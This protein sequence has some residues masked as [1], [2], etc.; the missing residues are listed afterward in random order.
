MAPR[1]DPQPGE[2]AADGL[3][4]T[5]C[6]APSPR[7]VHTAVVQVPAHAHL[8]D[9]LALCMAHPQLASAV[10]AVAAGKLYCSVWGT[11]ATPDQ[12]LQP[13]DRI[14]LCRPL[15]VDPKVARRE[16]FAQQGAR[17]SGLFAQRRPGAK[18]GY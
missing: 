10:Q 14:E 17:T 15:R 7:V 3:T 11:K 9:A 5:V 2:A 16:R 18:S 6:Y 4:I 8:R 12:L 13:H 1:F